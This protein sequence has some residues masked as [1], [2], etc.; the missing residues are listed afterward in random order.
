MSL[1]HLHCYYAAFNGAHRWIYLKFYSS[2]IHYG[3]L[4][5]NKIFILLSFLNNISAKFKHIQPE[6]SY[7]SRILNINK[8]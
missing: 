1:S 8:T 6:Y 7:V 5:E 4:H 3:C 2:E